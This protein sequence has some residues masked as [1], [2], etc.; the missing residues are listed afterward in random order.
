MRDGLP[1]GKPF[2][3]W[4]LA[5]ILIPFSA[6]LFGVVMIISVGHF[7]DDTVSD[8]YYKEGLAINKRF[9]ESEKKGIVDV[10]LVDE[11]NAEIRLWGEWTAPMRIAVHHIADSDQDFVLDI[12]MESQ[13]FKENIVKVADPKLNQVLR[14]AGVWY[15]ELVSLE[16]KTLSAYRLVAPLSKS[17]GAQPDGKGAH[18]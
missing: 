16:G 4:P 17:V 18:Q 10:R 1:K 11:A 8:E 13:N 6:V 12:P 14:Q 3:G 15:L 7:P 2:N 5:L 9:S